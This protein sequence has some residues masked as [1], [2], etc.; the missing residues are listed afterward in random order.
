MMRPSPKC[1]ARTPDMA[2]LPISCADGSAE[3]P[4][5]AMSAHSRR[6]LLTCPL[7]PGRCCSRKLHGPHAARA[8]TVLPTS[9]DVAIHDSHLNV[10]LDCACL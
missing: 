9:D 5:L 10:W 3:P 4:T 2:S 8:F 1:R 6:T 7:R